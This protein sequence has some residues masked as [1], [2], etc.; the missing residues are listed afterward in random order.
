MDSD[1][2]R[3]DL[4]TKPAKLPNS[5]KAIGDHVMSRSRNLNLLMELRPAMAGFAGIP[6][7]TRLLF[8][9][10][11]DIP[12]I[13]TTGLINHSSLA[14]SPGLAR[15]RTCPSD[16]LT[17]R[18]RDILSR[19]IKSHEAPGPTELTNSPSFLVK[20]RKQKVHRRAQA[21]MSIAQKL[22]YFQPEN[23]QD[24]IWQT[25]FSKTLPD[26]DFD[27]ATRGDFAVLSAPYAEMHGTR[28]V[29]LPYPRMSTDNYDIFVA[30]TP[31]PS[32]VSPRTQL[33]VRYHDAVP[34]FHPHTIM[35]KSFHQSSH[36]AALRENQKSGV[37]ACTS[38][39]TRQ[40][41]LKIFPN[42]EER[43]VV[44]PDIV[45]HCYFEQ[46]VSPERRAGIIRNHIEPSTEPNWS[47]T[48]KRTKFY[49]KNVSSRSLRYI[50]MVSTIEPR[51]NHIALIAAWDRLRA[52]IGDNLKLIIVGSPGWSSE[53]VIDAMRP[54][55]EKGDLFNLSKV[56]PDS[57]RVLFNGAE[58][59][60]CPSVCEGFDLSGIEAML[61][62]APVVASDIPVHREVYAE[63]S[64]YFDPY[65]EEALADAMER[66]IVQPD[67]RRALISR[68]LQQGR[69][70]TRESIGAQ[71]EVFFDRV[72][73]EEFDQTRR[74]RTT[75]EVAT[76]RNVKGVFSEQVFETNI[77]STA[78][79]SR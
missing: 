47:D 36:M 13:T 65:C 30:Q 52:R 71:W 2:L 50:M 68:G 40:D 58:A 32:R 1:T 62:G 39:A 6:Q 49:N 63:A 33:V 37:F 70:Y 78:C 17:E 55:Q 75:R 46:S 79:S 19:H 31:W 54:W 16:T 8:S 41:L 60:I 21:V 76:P 26:G 42:L 45:S 28:L 57:L 61:S 72:R 4:P 5:I 66:V 59:V 48:R 9:L 12:D 38:E 43:S 3:T 18:E 27:K 23:F 56:P 73:A 51:K 64:E 24:F 7:E 35:D 29:G 20:S 67:Y 11:H 14:L 53:A 69:K 74:Q 15:R 22:T 10:Y 44:I 77:G 25:F 34:I